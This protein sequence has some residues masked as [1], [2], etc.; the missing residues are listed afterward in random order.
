MNLIPITVNVV[1]RKEM[2]RNIQ[3]MKEIEYK[4]RAYFIIHS[5]AVV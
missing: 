3:L 5:R 1:T 4:R 2:M